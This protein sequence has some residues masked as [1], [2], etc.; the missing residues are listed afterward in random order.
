MKKKF[1]R[2]LIEELLTALEPKKAAPIE[3]TITRD[4]L[5]TLLDAAGASLDTIMLRAASTAD[6]WV[7][8]ANEFNKKAD[9]LRAEAN[10]AE[11][12]ALRY[13]ANA[14]EVTR[15][16]AALGEPK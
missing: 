6:N 3:P 14:A 9:S 7:G 2:R 5:D 13:Q 4:Q 10:N 11:S 1:L 16:I 8:F 15:A 12:K